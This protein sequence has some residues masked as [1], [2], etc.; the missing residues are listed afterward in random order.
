[1][2]EK[3]LGSSRNIRDVALSRFYNDTED[4]EYSRE[5]NNNFKEYFL[6]TT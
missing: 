4:D 3:P 5:E 1:M 6:T 2:P